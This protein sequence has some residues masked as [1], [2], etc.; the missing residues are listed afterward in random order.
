MRSYQIGG[1]YDEHYLRRQILKDIIDGVKIC[2]VFLS[3]LFP[4]VCSD[5]FSNFFV[6]VD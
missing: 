2:Q 3:Q 4:L 6:A 1:P 5:A